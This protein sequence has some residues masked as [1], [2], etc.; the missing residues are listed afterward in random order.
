MPRARSGGCRCRLLKLAICASAAV[1]AVVA[2]QQCADGIAAGIGTCD[3]DSFE[4]GTRFCDANSNIA[5]VK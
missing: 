5:I 4:E 1:T 2:Q 3:E